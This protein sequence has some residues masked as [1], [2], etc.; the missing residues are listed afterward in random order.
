M[1]FVS[2]LLDGALRYASKVGPDAETVIKEHI[3]N[4]HKEK[5]EMPQDNKERKKD[6]KYRAERRMK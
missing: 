1:A 4:R 5:E 3:S 6:K 2:S